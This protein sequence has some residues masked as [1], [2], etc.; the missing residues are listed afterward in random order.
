MQKMFF[1][2][3]Q[4]QHNQNADIIVPP[5]AERH[6]MS[7]INLATDLFY[8]Y[9]IQGNNSITVNGSSS[10]ISILIY[11][12]VILQ[13]MTNIPCQL[14][15]KILKTVLHISP[16]KGTNWIHLKLT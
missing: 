3:N 7:I 1:L 5:Q 12:T 6:S 15:W 16:L 13:K 8:K 2:M 4:I 11:I 10:K 9:S 14:F